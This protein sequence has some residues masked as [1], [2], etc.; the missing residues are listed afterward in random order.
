MRIDFRTSPSTDGSIKFR[1]ITQDNYFIEA[2]FFY[3]HNNL[4]VLC[5]SSQ[6]GCNM[7]CKFCGTAKQ[8][9]IR[10]LTKDEIVQQAVL[11]MNELFP[12]ENPDTITLAGM[13]EPLANYE[14][15]LSALEEFR[16][17]YGDIRLSLS[18]V[19]LKVGLERMIKEKRSFGLYISLHAA[20]DEERQKIM[21]AAKHISVKAL[22]DLA[23]QYAKMNKPG[24]VRV[25]YLLL[26]GKTDT[27]KQLNQLIDLLKGKDIIL[28]IRLWNPVEGIEL[29]RISMEKANAWVKVLQEHQIKAV[30]R[31]S[32]GQE[33]EGGCGQMANN[34]CKNRVYSIHSFKEAIPYMNASD[35]RSL[36]V[37]DVDS[38]LIVP[39][40][41]YLNPVSFNRFTHI[42]KKLYGNLTREQKHVINHSIIAHSPK[43]VEEY[44][45][46]FIQFLKDN[47]LNTVI[48]QTAAKPGVFDHQR[49]TFSKIRDRQLK[50][51][52]ISFKGE[53]S[54]EFSNLKDIYG[55]YP[56]MEKG[57][58][59]SACLLNTKGDVLKEFLKSEEPFD[60]IVLFDDKKK[61]IDSIGQMVMNSF[62]Q[63][64]FVG[65]HYKGAD[66][67]KESEDVLEEEFEKY[68]LELIE[69][70]QDLSF[71]IE[72]TFIKD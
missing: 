21:P 17:L 71:L 50:A 58:I 31:P 5:L 2:L 37:F 67:L 11:I 13:G 10:N 70:N 8:K 6:I 12:G 63:T 69:K 47:Q 42:V 59:Y 43:L 52:G 7:G 66:L 48:A 34:S 3:Y 30:V 60:Q 68:L 45:L 41:K 9:L 72:K 29:K 36:I 27:P 23:D 55:D 35:K 51:L 40:N 56:K 20:S 4:K 26:E 22:I 16:S 61:H 15:S 18:T 14:A 64:S 53:N 19:G 24:L 1:F 57:I 25:S 39:K 49:V 65:F 38:V 32:A 44:A 33:L 54:L 46:E 62:P 28:Q